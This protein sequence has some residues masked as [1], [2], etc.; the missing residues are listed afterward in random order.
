MQ[1][2][3]THRIGGAA[4]GSAKPGQMV[5]FSSKTCTVVSCVNAAVLGQEY[6]LV[7]QTLVARLK[8]RVGAILLAI[9]VSPV[10]LV[11]WMTCFSKGLRR[12]EAAVNFPQQPAS[13][14]PSPEPQPPSKTP[15]ASPAREA[16]ANQSGEVSAVFAE[17]SVVE[18]IVIVAATRT[19]RRVQ[20]GFKKN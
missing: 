4:L 5:Q 11:R 7:H 9:L 6:C 18:E 10:A 1:P 13:G 19:R 3:S 14:V 17:Q 8:P 16:T 12:K 20:L 15:T 2:Q